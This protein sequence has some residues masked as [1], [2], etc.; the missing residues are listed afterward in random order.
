MSRSPS[1]WF[2][3]T[4]SMTLSFGR[5]GSIHNAPISLWPHGSVKDHR[6]IRQI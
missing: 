6:P 2:I 4:P 3:A 1:T 5:N